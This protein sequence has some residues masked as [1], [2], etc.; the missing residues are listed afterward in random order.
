MTAAARSR[1]G[2]AT[3][4]RALDAQIEREFLAITDAETTAT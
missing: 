1:P 2:S 4:S 3:T